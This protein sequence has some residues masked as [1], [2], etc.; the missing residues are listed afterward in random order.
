MTLFPSAWR[1][2]RFPRMRPVTKS[3]FRHS[4]PRDTCHQ[5]R[6][7]DDP[8]RRVTHRETPNAAMPVVRALS[9]L[10][11]PDLIQNKRVPS[12]N[13]EKNQRKPLFFGTPAT[14]RRHPSAR[15]LRP[16]GTRHRYPSPAHHT[17]H[18]RLCP[19]IR[20]PCRRAP[21]AKLSRRTRARLRFHTRGVGFGHV[22]LHPPV[23][24]FLVCFATLR[25]R[26]G[27]VCV[28]IHA[29]ARSVATDAG[30]S[31]GADPAWVRKRFVQGW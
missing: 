5:T 12:E 30:R 18:G 19:G 4:K 14:H 20:P 25:Q 8:Y 7:C 31:G 21:G 16:A 23:P 3:T 26:R 22:I 24:A 2:R 9:D 11:P 15:H 17:R 1:R 28:S 27:R 13:R 29:H 10:P 6:L